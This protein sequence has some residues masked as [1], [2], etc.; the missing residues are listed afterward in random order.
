MTHWYKDLAYIGYV[1]LNRTQQVEASLEALEL[2][3]VQPHSSG[4]N[5]FDRFYL[6]LSSYSRL[7]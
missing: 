4:I 2:S 1:R 7:T 6:S 5:F 3:Y